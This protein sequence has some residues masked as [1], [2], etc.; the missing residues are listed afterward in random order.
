MFFVCNAC[1]DTGTRPSDSIKGIVSSLSPQSDKENGVPPYE[2]RITEGSMRSPLPVLH[3]AVLGK[4][5]E[6]D[7][8]L[9]QNEE[10]RKLEEMEQMKQIRQERQRRLG[11]ERRRLQELEKQESQGHQQQ[12]HCRRMRDEENK[13]KKP[14]P[15][16]PLHKAEEEALMRKEQAQ[17]Q[18][19]LL[20]YLAANEFPSVN[21][22]KKVPGLLTAGF[23]YPLHLAARA[24]DAEAVEMLLSAGAD[25]TLQDSSK[26]TPLALAMRLDKKGSHA[27]VIELLSS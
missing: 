7:G 25:R 27:A 9:T 23:T 2:L 12:E 22:K 8:S 20:M 21:E 13:E 10:V 14:T 6:L 18:E 17:K 15:R 5:F 19:R 4:E 1:T 16:T 24:P 26:L 11:E 3:G